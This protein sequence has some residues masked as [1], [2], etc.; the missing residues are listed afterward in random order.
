MNATPN[1]RPLGRSGL[2]TLPLALGGNV[3]GWTADQQMSHAILDRFVDAGFSLVDTADVY[4]KWVPGNTGGESETIIGNWLKARGGRER[5]LVATKVGGE[6]HPGQKGLS[7]QHIKTAVE[8]SLKR[9]QTD[10]IDLYQA[11]YNDDTV[12]FEETLGAFDDLIKAGK[13]R[14]IGVSNHD[15]DRLKAAMEV[16][17]ARGLPRY[18]VLQPLYNLYDRREFEQIFAPLCC[19]EDIGVISF[20]A[21]ANGFLSGKYRT[22]DDVSASRRK[23]SNQAYM[24]A[25]GFRILDALDA[26]AERNDV[27][28]AQ[29]AIAWTAAQSGITAPI[30]SATSIPQIDSLLVAARLSLDADALALLDRASAY[31]P[32]GAHA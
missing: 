21:L 30:A 5:L 3:F 8:G 32:A 23:A 12:A 19:A 24:N 25:R 1:P 27:T 18:E 26:V 10:Y 6:L 4:S 17:R 22:A 11:H 2:T 14:A 16:S 7:A 29:V 20:K 15:P 9:L 28:P 31:A 13:V